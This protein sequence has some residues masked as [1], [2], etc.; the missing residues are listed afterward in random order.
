M[1][2]GPGLAAYYL[3]SLEL[4]NWAYFS[5]PPT[6]TVSPQPLLTVLPN[7]SV[8]V[9]QNPMCLEIFL[10]FHALSLCDASRRKLPRAPPMLIVTAILVLMHDYSNNSRISKK[11]KKQVTVTF[12]SCIFAEYEE[13]K[14]TMRNTNKILDWNTG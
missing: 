10:L 5:S 7:Q 14:R 1:H 13:F 6:L 4:H 8:D 12:K 9:T 2:F 3:L 11:Y